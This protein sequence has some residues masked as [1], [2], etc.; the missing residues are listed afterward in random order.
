MKKYLSYI[1][2]FLLSFIV[3]FNISALEMPEIQSRN[4]FFINVDRDDVIYE[5]S[6][7]DKVL[8]ASLTKIMTTI[9]AIEKIDNYEKNSNYKW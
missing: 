9:T 3:M 6:P 1:L 8:I 4:V 5:K 2:V 7:D